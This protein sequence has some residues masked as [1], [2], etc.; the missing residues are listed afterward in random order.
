MDCIF[1]KIVKGEIPAKIIAD[2]EHSLAFIDAFPLTKGHSLVIPKNHYEKI[3]DM[4]SDDNADLFKTV[5]SVIA[6]VDNPDNPQYHEKTLTE[7]E[8]ALKG[9]FVTCNVQYRDKK[10]DVLVCNVFVQNPPEGF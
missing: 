6:K 2:T 9:K 5:H 4:S 8:Q 1:C 3:Q 7:L 10:T